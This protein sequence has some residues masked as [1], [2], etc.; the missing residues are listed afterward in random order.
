MIK[1]MLRVNVIISSI[2]AE[3]FLDFRKP[4]P[5]IHINTN[6]NLTEMERKPD[7]SLEV[8]FVLTISYNPSV[9]QINLKGVAFVIGD[10]SEI[11]SAYKDYEDKKPPPPMV[12]Q[13]VSNVALTESILIA[14]TLNIPPP[15]P[16]PQVTTET[17]QPGTKASG[18]EYT[19]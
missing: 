4:F 10:K 19:A 5:Q 13:S 8:G 12:L 15:V 1:K 7:N 14:K 2:S 6:L 9:A 16:L 18:K 3:R 11:D 17:K